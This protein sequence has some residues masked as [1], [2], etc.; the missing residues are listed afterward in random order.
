VPE[1]AA[2]GEI[3]RSTSPVQLT[4]EGTEYCVT[5]TKHITSSAVI[6]QF[7]CT[8]TVEEQVLEAISVAVDLEDAVCYTSQRE[9]SVPN[10]FQ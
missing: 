7:D 1:L 5:A 6:L 9:A 4:E 8:N 10:V 2:V 3:F